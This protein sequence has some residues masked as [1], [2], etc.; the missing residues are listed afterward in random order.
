[1]DLVAF[2]E[3]GEPPLLISLG[4]MSLGENDL[5]TASL[6]VKAIIDADVRA[7]IQGW[8]VGM[9]QMV[10]PPTIYP[11]GSMPHSWLLPRCSG[12]VHH[13][14]YGTTAAGFQAGIPELVIPHI[15]DQFFWSEKVHDLGVGPKPI[16][17][18][19]LDGEK[20]TAALADLAENE[21]MCVAAKK[22]GEKIDDEP[23]VEN[24][25]KLIEETFL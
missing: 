20:L 13:G 9:K 1:M 11:A 12:L 19:D 25:V 6:F 24:A 7:I 18:T 14:G 2:L 21:Q 15:A 4:A 22:L 17:W 10:L 16:R 8:E 5:D 3:D 23:G